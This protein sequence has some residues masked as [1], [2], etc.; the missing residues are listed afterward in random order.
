MV[1]HLSW[2]FSAGAKCKNSQKCNV[3]SIKRGWKWKICKRLQRLNRGATLRFSSHSVHIVALYQWITQT[4]RFLFRPL[5]RSRCFWAPFSGAVC[6]LNPPNNRHI[7]SGLD[8]GRCGKSR[9]VSH[10]SDWTAMLVTSK[11]LCC[12]VQIFCGRIASTD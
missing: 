4:A 1:S 9:P 5:S 12:I 2:C 3:H 11:K 10:W 7:S 8:W 6:L